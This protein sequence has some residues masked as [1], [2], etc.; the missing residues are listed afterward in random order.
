ML[1]S[2][3]ILSVFA[4]LWQGGE[5]VEMFSK[6]S[7]KTSKS[8][9]SGRAVGQ[10]N[11][12][13]VLTIGKSLAIVSRKRRQKSL[14]RRR[15]LSKQ[16]EEQAQAKS[17]ELSRAKRRLP[18]HDARLALAQNFTIRPY[19]EWVSRD[20][21]GGFQ[22]TLSSCWQG[23]AARHVACWNPCCS[24]CRRRHCVQRVAATGVRKSSC[25]TTF[26]PST[27]AGSGG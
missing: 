22:L 11:F 24:K 27:C 14:T 16:V 20:R 19:L 6:P 1:K 23:S 10:R 26:Q 21:A 18:T 13:L 2:C 3:V 25:R 4:L 12:G 9:S 8:G 7:S 15:K 5:R 17:Q